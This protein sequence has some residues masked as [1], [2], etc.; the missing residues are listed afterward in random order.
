MESK[1]EWYNTTW[2]V[3]LLCIVFFPVGLYAIWKSEVIAKGWKIAYTIVLAI[4]LIANIGGN[5]S[6]KASNENNVAVVDTLATTNEGDSTTTTT[7]NNWNY[8]QEFDEM[9]SSTSYFAWS[10]STNTLDFQFPYEGGS[11]FT[12]T[13]RKN[14]SGT[15]VYLKVSKGQFMTSVMGEESLRIKFDEEKPQSFSYSSAADGSS[16]IIFINS[17]SRLINKLKTAKKII[18][19]TT[20]YNEGKQKVYFNVEGLDW[21]HKI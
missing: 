16:D 7:P 4:V 5:D 11:S 13:V 19:E 21:K 8:S 10:E 15:N 1:K 20:F 9:N 2:L 17:E 3:I 18:I 14:A 12:L 6:A